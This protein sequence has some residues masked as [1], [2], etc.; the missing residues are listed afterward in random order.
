[1]WITCGNIDKLSTRKYAHGD[2]FYCGSI[3]E[4]IGAEF[5]NHSIDNDLTDGDGH[6]LTIGILL[7]ALPPFDNQMAPST[8]VPLKMGEF[9]V[10]VD[11]DAKCDECLD[12]TF[13]N[14][15]NGSEAL[16]VD[17]L[18]A[19]D[20]QSY[21]Q[22]A[23]TSC[24]VCI[25][26]GAR[27]LRGDCNGDLRHDIADPATV[28]GFQFQGFEVAC[29]DACDANDDGKVNL[30]DTVYLLNFLFQSGATPLE[31]FPNPGLDPTEDQLD[32]E[33]GSFTCP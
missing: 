5:V 19:I 10:L 6:E 3:L 13:C 30:A 31:P 1:M 24:S 9:Q 16:P 8:L 11:D 22:F 18:V 17:N 7:D 21:S 25:E 2:F 12:I 28:L 14:G 15:I 23:L 32:C 29:M 4:A 20:F 27:F 33:D 26:P